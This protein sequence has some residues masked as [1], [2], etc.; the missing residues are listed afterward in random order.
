MQVKSLLLFVCL[1]V[2]TIAQGQYSFRV[3]TGTY[4][5]LSNSTSLNSGITWDD[6]QFEIPIGFDFQ[7]YDTIINTLHLD[8][9][10]LGGEFTA[11][12]NETGSYALL[13]PYGADIIDRGFDFNTGPAPGSQS[14]ISYVLDGDPGNRI[15]KIQ[16][17]NVGFYGEMDL[18]N[19]SSDFTNFQMWIYEGLNDIELHFGPNSISQP[20]D[21]YNGFPG[22]YI[23][24]FPAY[25]FDAQEAE[26]EG[27]ALNGD[28][29]NPT[30]IKTSVAYDHSLEGTIPNGTIYRF[31]TSGV[32]IAEKAAPN[33]SL[34]P[35]PADDYVVLTS[36][37]S[38]ERIEYVRVY[39][40]KGQ[41]V[42]NTLYNGQRLDLT[43]IAPGVYNLQITTTSG[44]AN[45]R[46]IKQ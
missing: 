37:N 24:F 10:G 22:T 20:N 38:G 39:N 6:P 13:V 19:V 2:T 17:Q 45:Q 4:T 18:D 21:S 8:D 40:S 33:V 36:T 29:S 23:G 32:G 46:L 14:D 27:I 1:V 26:G 5:E 15:L 7:Y 43:A 3:S 35:V 44:T 31:S 30:A 9:W 34:H 11:G 12:T 28:P 25:N 41:E 16:W 42:I